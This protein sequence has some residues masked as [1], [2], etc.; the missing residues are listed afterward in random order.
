VGREICG[1]LTNQRLGVCSSWDLDV[2]PIVRQLDA[3]A[4]AM[5]KKDGV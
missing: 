4:C 1:I 5:R 2:R 3:D